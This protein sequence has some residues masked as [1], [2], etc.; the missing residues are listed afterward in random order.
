MRDDGDI[1]AQ[2]GRACV[3]LSFTWSAH[4]SM[5]IDNV[6]DF[7]HAHL[8]RRYRYGTYFGVRGL[9]GAGA[10]PSDPALRLA[11]RWLLDR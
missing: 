8:H 7:S 3:P 9:V 11:C 6:S 2:P 1:P 10:R 4:H 5:V